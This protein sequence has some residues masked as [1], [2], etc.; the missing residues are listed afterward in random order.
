MLPSLAPYVA[1]RVLQVGMLAKKFHFTGLAR[2]APKLS[3]P[4]KLVF[5]R[6]ACTPMG[7]N[8]IHYLQSVIILSRISGLLILK[9]L[10]KVKQKTLEINK[11]FCLQC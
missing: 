8:M 4:G 11:S 6:Y 7:C 2:E 9:N 5:P 3:L 1:E 10:F